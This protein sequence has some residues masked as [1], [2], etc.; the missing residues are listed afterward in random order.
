MRDEIV[1][2]PNKDNNKKIFGNLYP[3]P[4]KDPT[5]KKPGEEEAITEST[6]SGPLEY[7]TE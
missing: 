7:F 1:I 4:Q 2:N 6:Q 3:Q 5:K